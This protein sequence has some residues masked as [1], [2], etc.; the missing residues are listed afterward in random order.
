[1]LGES[2]WLNYGKL[3]TREEN[4]GQ[5]PNWHTADSQKAEKTP[6]HITAGHS[7]RWIELVYVNRKERETGLEECNR[8]HAS[9]YLISAWNRS[10]MKLALKMACTERPLCTFS[11]LRKFLYR[12]L[13]LLSGVTASELEPAWQLPVSSLPSQYLTMKIQSKAIQ[14][15][16][17]V[18]KGG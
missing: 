15:T 2:C 14:F 16:F 9:T 13:F 8:R 1:M 4:D 17:L 18:P 11:T 12:K 7:R 3:F 5:F 10:V 6:W